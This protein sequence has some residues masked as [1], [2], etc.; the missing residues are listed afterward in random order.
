MGVQLPTS[1]GADFFHQTVLPFLHKTT[2]HPASFQHLPKKKPGSGPEPEVHTLECG[3]DLDVSEHDGT[4]K[5]SI[6]IGIPLETIHFWGTSI[7]GNNH[8]LE[9][10]GSKL[11]DMDFFVQP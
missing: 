5:S 9:L 3:C 4:P 7:F 2:N 11:R 6:F 10:V 8:L 1:T